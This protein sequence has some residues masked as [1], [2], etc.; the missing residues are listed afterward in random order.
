MSSAGVNVGGSFTSIGGEVEGGF[1][2]LAP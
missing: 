1:A 2:T